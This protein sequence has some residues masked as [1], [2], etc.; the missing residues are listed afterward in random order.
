MSPKIGLALSGG[1]FR[2]AA[3]GLGS[4]RA[5]HDRGLLRQVTVVSG[6]S[7]GS[8]LTAMWAYGPER[9]DEFDDSVTA[10]LRNGLQSELVRRAFAPRA[11]GRAIISA[12]HALGSRQGRSYSRTDA[13]VEA[14]AAR[15]F[16]ARLVQ[17]I[18]HAGTNTVISS[19]DMTTGNAVR[20]GSALSACSPYG[21]I[22]SD[23][24]VAEA[25]AASAAFPILLPALHRSYEF[26]DRDGAHRTEHMVMTDGG[27]Y[28]NLGL[29]PLLPGRSTRHSSHVYDLDYIFAVDAGRGRSERSA[30][31]FMIGRLAQSFDITHTK[32]Q[33][34]GRSRVHLARESGD[35]KG[36][37]HV[38]L[39]MRDER[40]PTPLADL[41]PRAEVHNYPTNFA[42]MKPA[43]LEAIAIRGEQLTRTLLNTYTSDLGM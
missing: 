34:A 31:R 26:R 15:D 3:F 42:P 41:V 32:S 9:F 1:G 18:T 5:L 16:G 13:L 37:V 29:A 4:L 2:A 22:V 14:L 11:T 21:T 24:T 33:D 8:L 6:I 23:V 19:T 30:A 12:V 10:L 38:Y 35:L 25:V 17:D 36:F 43:D 27:V 28:D 39:G 40:L 7:G 20:F